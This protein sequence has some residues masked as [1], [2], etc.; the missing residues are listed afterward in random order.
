MSAGSRLED[1]YRVGKEYFSGLPMDEAP[2]AVACYNDLVALGLMRALREMDI[3][4]PEMVSLTGFDDVNL[5]AFSAV[6]LTTMRVPKREMG[7][8]AVEVL[9]RQM[10]AGGDYR[11]EQ[12]TL[13]AELVVRG[14]TGEPRQ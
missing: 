14:S 2:T 3:L 9:I 12:V 8:R 5:S 10:E 6:P 13:Q 1:G 11:P 7:Q 4:V